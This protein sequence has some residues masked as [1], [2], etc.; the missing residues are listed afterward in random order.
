[1][2]T[3]KWCLKWVQYTVLLYEKVCFRSGAVKENLTEEV[4]KESDTER[5]KK[6]YI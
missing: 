4:Y 2:V 3:L 1:M 5:K 6:Q